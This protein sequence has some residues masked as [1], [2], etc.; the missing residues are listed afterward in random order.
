MK[1]EIDWASPLRTGATR[2]IK[3]AVG[4]D[5]LWQAKDGFSLLIEVKTTDAYRINLDTIANYR[6]KLIAQGTLQAHSSSVVVAVGRQQ[7][8]DLEAQ[9]R[10]SRHAWD[11]R[12]ISLEALL[13][14][15]EVKER[16]SDWST[17]NKINQLL[18]PVEYT[19]LDPIVELLFTT[20]RDLETPEE[21]PPPSEVATVNTPERIDKGSL[22]RRRG[23]SQLRVLQGS[24]RVSLSKRRGRFAS[25]PMAKCESYVSPLNNMR[26]PGARGT[27]GMGS[28][29]PSASI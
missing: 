26:A 28:R 5:G 29:R 1:L 7:T 25:R 17:S 14:L 20:K 19:R 4:N 2:G 22:E 9:I 21:V 3:G 11:V 15:A 6:E 23:R 16:L 18:R 24:S 8:G 13:R 12:L 27:I 10:G